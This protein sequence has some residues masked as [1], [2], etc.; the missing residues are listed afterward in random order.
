MGHESLNITM[1]YARLF[2]QTVM[3]DYFKAVDT[4]ETQ[5]GGAWHEIDMAS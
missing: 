4:I 1:V 3:L 5:P 2:D